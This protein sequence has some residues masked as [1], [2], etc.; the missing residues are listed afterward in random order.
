M[1]K[2]FLK[3]L[4][5][6]HISKDQKLKAQLAL[7]EGCGIRSHD[8]KELQRLYIS[9]VLLVAPAVLAATGEGIL[10]FR[11]RTALTTSQTVFCESAPLHSPRRS[12]NYSRVSSPLDFF[13]INGSLQTLS[14]C[15]KRNRNH[16]LEITAQSLF[17][18]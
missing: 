17:Y 16:V 15:T 6:E 13:L 5:I 2:I 9:S 18:R 10:T 7:K 11:K 12:Q 14:L 3:V 8:L 4:Q 1:L